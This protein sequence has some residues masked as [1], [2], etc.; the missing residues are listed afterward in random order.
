MVTCTIVHCKM[1]TPIPNLHGKSF[2]IDFHLILYD[3]CHT[4][5]FH[6]IPSIIGV[7]WKNHPIEAIYLFFFHTSTNQIF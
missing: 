7:H 6:T 3:F 5:I 4:M 2:S 1:Y